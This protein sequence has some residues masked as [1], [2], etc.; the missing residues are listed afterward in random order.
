[1]NQFEHICIN[2]EFYEALRDRANYGDCFLDCHGND[3][4]RTV[5]ATDSCDFWMGSTVEED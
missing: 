1:M 4:M 2:C 5:K 3:G